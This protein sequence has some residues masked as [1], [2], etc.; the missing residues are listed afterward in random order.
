MHQRVLGEPHGHFGTDGPNKHELVEI[1]DIDLKVVELSQ[2]EAT[3]ALRFRHG[4]HRGGSIRFQDMN[5]LGVEFD[6]VHVL[7]PVQSLR[8]YTIKGACI[9]ALLM[10]C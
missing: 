8:P 2:P 9:A 6:L 10:Q 4:Q 3:H 1:L 7:M 5:E